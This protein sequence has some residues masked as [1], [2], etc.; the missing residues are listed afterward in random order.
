MCLSLGSYVIYSCSGEQRLGEVVR[1]RPTE[2]GTLYDVSA[3]QQTVYGLLEEELTPATEHQ[4][5]AMLSYLSVSDT[6]SPTYLTDDTRKARRDALLRQEYQRRLAAALASFA[7]ADGGPA[8]AARFSPHE[9]V[10]IH[11]NSSWTLGQ[12]RSAEL[13]KGS[14]RYV[15]DTA[16]DTGHYQ[17]DE[18]SALAD[19]PEREGC[20]RLGSRARMVGGQDA[21]GGAFEGVIC[22]IETG[23]VVL[24]SLL[25]DDGDIFEELTAQ[26][27][28]PLD[29]RP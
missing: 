20:L 22:H 15:V 10:A 4:V 13:A 23:E 26:D 19:I 8:P 2:L 24:H 16:D 7:Q 3:E 28:I 27:L 14:V 25:F 11:Q 6:F 5:R 18:L 17:E 21:D 29:T 12:V 9:L 1:L